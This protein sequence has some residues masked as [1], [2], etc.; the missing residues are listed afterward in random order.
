[1]VQ[2]LKDPVTVK[3]MVSKANGD[4]K[5]LT[6]GSFTEQQHDETGN[7]A[8]SLFPSSLSDSVLVHSSFLSHLD[9]D[10][11]TH[12]EGKQSSKATSDTVV[13]I[14]FDQS[15]RERRNAV[16][17]QTGVGHLQRTTLG[18]NTYV[19]ESLSAGTSVSTLGAPL[20]NLINGAPSEAV[21]KSMEQTLNSDATVVSGTTGGQELEEVSSK[22]SNVSGDILMEKE[23]A[24]LNLLTLANQFI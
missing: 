9:S 11:Q 1:M 20:V 10:M 24:A 19:A 17:A 7:K 23:Q 4:Q 15:S 22:N 21:T 5:P 3:V 12:V 13:S 6:V 2:S 16:G 14:T 18:S 8:S